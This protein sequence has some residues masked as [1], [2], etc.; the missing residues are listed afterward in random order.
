MEFQKLE[1][2]I[3]ACEQKLSGLRAQYDKAVSCQANLFTAPQSP[4]VKI[5]T[6][7]SY[8]WTK[9]V[10]GCGTGTICVV[11]GDE[12]PMIETFKMCFP[13][14]NQLINRFELEAIK[15]AQNLLES[16]KL[17]GIIY[18]DSQIAV[19]WSRN[20][21]VKWTP[22]QLNKAGIILDQYMKQQKTRSK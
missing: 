11:V 3:Q 22:R 14:L 7:A 2:E 18:S 21:L 9:T 12:K 10:D 15:R 4:L 1:K 20:P 8:S 6:D 16:R 5:F 19:K 13:G 17:N